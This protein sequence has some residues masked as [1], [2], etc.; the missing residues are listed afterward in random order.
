MLDM[1]R[2]GMEG[3]RQRDDPICLFQIHQS[4]TGQSIA[5]WPDRFEQQQLSG[6]ACRQEHEALYVAQ[7]VME[8]EVQRFNAHGK[9]Q[10][11][12]ESSHYYCIVPDRK[13]IACTYHVRSSSVIKL[14]DDTYRMERIIVPYG[15]IT[16]SACQMTKILLGLQQ[17]SGLGGNHPITYQHYIHCSSAPSTAA[18]LSR[19]GIVVSDKSLTETSE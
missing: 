11:E 17:S 7:R 15:A 2:R 6:F 9:K 13:E 3:D 5:C 14:S 18:L 12:E 4:T 1:L 19:C 10:Q 8:Q 16:F